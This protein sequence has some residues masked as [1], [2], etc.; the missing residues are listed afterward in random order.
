M[1][2]YK[3]T[4]EKNI[5]K[6]DFENEYDPQEYVKTLLDQKKKLKEYV[7]QK[8]IYDAKAHNV[9]EFHP[10]V[11]EV[12]EEKKNEIWLYH[13]NIVSSKQ[14]ET[15]IEVVKENIEKLEKEMKDIEEQTEFKFDL[16]KEE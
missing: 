11:L 16:P 15:L 3:L 1:P 8:G 4:E 9:A 6:S 5:I 2:T 13:E 12:E 10:H 14:M 7:A